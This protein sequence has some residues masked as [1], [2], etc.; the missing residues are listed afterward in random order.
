MP[1]FNAYMRGEEGPKGSSGQAAI[2]DE[3]VSSWQ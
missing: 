1:K 3:Y 2:Y